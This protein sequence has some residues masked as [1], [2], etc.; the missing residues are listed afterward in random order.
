M[1]RN[2]SKTAVPLSAKRAAVEK[3]MDIDRFKE[4]LPLIKRE[5]KSFISFYK[6]HIIPAIDKKITEFHASL[7]GTVCPYL[8]KVIIPIS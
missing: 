3:Q 6:D 5:M 2:C 7:T 1:I 4:E 8:P